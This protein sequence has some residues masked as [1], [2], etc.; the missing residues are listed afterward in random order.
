MILITVIVFIIVIV[1]HELAHGYTAYIMGDTTA[2]DA[3][4]LTL[5]PIAHADPIGTVLLPVLLISM[6]SPVVFGWAKPVPVNPGNFRDP[7]KGMFLTSLAGPMANFLIA[8]FF[9]AFFKTGLFLKYSFM[10]NFLL[11]GIL[12]SLVLGIFNLLPIPPLDGANILFSLLPRRLYR[13]F[14]MMEKYGFIL[15]FI[16]LYLGLFEKVILPLVSIITDIL[17]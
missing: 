8:A 16:L 5:N 17:I 15:L 3:G 11:T 6:R 10:W 2:R 13:Y 7:R 1:V 9:A 4:R 14:I 12:I